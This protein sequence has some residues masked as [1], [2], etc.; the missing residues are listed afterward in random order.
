VAQAIDGAQ[1]ITTRGA[2]SQLTPVPVQGLSSGVQAAA[3]CGGGS[4]PVKLRALPSSNT[5][6]SRISGQPRYMAPMSV[7]TL[8]DLAGA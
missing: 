1:S 8:L 3:R 6:N 2:S 5:E 7:K 4:Q